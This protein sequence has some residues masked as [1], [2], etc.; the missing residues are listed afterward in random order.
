MRKRV[1]DVYVSPTNPLLSGAMESIVALLDNGY[2]AKFALGICKVYERRLEGG[3]RYWK[4]GFTDPNRQSLVLR[5]DDE[6]L[7]F[8]NTV[9][10]EEK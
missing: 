1:E 5:N 4:I 3:F 9:Q 8:I 10:L 7:Q 2:R 6:V